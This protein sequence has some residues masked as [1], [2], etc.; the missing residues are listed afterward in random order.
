MKSSSGRNNRKTQ[1]T[2]FAYVERFYLTLKS[3]GERKGA[4]K[5]YWMSYSQLAHSGFGF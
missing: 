2:A 4:K 3:G 5:K 1:P